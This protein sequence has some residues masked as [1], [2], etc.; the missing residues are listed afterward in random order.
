MLLCCVVLVH[1]EVNFT[2][3]AHVGGLPRAISSMQH[4]AGTTAGG[5]V[6]GVS[7]YYVNPGVVVGS[8]WA[9]QQVERSFVGIVV[10]VVCFI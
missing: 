9:L 5:V 8:A 2:R 6:N 4:G 3:T 1:V 7:L 10:N